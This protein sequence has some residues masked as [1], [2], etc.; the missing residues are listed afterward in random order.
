MKKSRI[1][2]PIFI[3]K[4]F[5]KYNPLF[6][7]LCIIEIIIFPLFNF[8]SVYFPKAF[9]EEIDIVNDFYDILILI[10]VYSLCLFFSG[11]ISNLFSYYKTISSNLMINKLQV[12][13]TK[14]C[15]DMDYYF[16]E[17]NKTREQI[18][19]IKD[20]SSLIDLFNIYVNI[21]VNSLTIFSISSLIVY[22]DFRL[23]LMLL[24]IYVF[25]IFLS[26]I[27][28][29]MLNKNMLQESKNNKVGRYLDKCMYFNESCGKEIRVNSLHN[30]FKKK[31]I[32][33]REEMVGV[34]IKTLKIDTMIEIIDRI[35]YY[36]QMF[37]ILLFLLNQ[38]LKG[39]I[40][41]S[42][43]IVYFN[44]TISIINYLSLF[45]KN[46]TVVKTKKFVIN[47]YLTLHNLT[48]TKIQSNYN[49]EVKFKNIV[50]ELRMF[51]LNIQMQM[52]VFYKI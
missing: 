11:I 6:F 9:I 8:V 2:F 43:F 1:F 46:I 18:E 52:S 36:F 27:K 7:I 39:I 12:G 15:C 29:K 24:I 40:L 34:Q 22:V 26:I 42:E 41:L 4:T 3:V 37:L 49:D 13:V 17:D 19:L 47:N 48:K 25:R 44:A 51:P 20:S 33:F 14:K 16:L 38:Y 21:V 10:I 32:N 23:I 45:S 5:F 50:F 31:V 35:V 28:Y 30:W